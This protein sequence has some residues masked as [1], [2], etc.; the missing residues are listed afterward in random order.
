V[1][2]LSDNTHDV[3]VVG[4][5][6]TG[7]TAAWRLSHR[8]L[9]VLLL[10]AGEHLSAQQAKP[11]SGL[12]PNIGR[13][14]RV[15]VSRRQRVQS[16]HPGYWM[17]H[18]DLFVDDKV[19]PYST[20]DGRTFVWIRGR[21]VGGRS[22][23]WGGLCLRLS[24]YEFE[25]WP[26]RYED[27]APYYD[28]VERVMGV[29]GNQDGV[30]QLPNGSYHTEKSLTGAERVF[31]DRIRARWP[32]RQVVVGR[33]VDR[34]A[35]S[36]WARKS[37]LGS[38]LEAAARS[39]LVNIQPGSV[40]R[41]IVVDDASGR[42]CGVEIVDQRTKEV[43]RVPARAVVLC[44]STLESVRLLLNSRSPVHPSGLGDSTGQLGHYILNHISRS[45]T[46]KMKVDDAG[47]FR[48]FSPTESMLI[49]RYENVDGRT[50]DVRGGFGLWGGIQRSFLPPQLLNTAR[51]TAFGFM[52]GYGE[53]LAYF[54]N[55][56]A[57]EA[58]RRDAWGVPTLRIDV[59]YRDTDNDMA[60]RI[61]RDLREMVAAAQGE[62]INPAGRL[63]PIT[64]HLVER[65]QTAGINPGAFVHEVG[66]AR[67]GETRADSVVN[68]YC[69]LWDADNVFVTDGACWRTS[70]WQNPTLTM[71]AITARS[72]AYIADRFAEGAL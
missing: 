64:R 20:P 6:C 56:V 70:G 8:G 67:M 25:G 26:L 47:E 31:R 65:V 72:C 69:Q 38:T 34:T 29:N 5:G 43:R 61:D 42:A 30:P 59:R 39:G 49:P 51:D 54:D 60:D 12:A 44:A 16:L 58:D 21:Q 1:A 48:P 19:H 3:V 24:P 52:I 45:V 37:S 28:E 68:Q 2:A 71:M 22:L 55:Q 17:Y 10:E 27:L 33:G 46:F 35:D 9:R 13:A 66:G 14:W 41:R 57:L 23:T 15:L 18:P 36:G 7:G 32:D 40:A 50:S 62:V 4:S 63:D 11:T 53:C